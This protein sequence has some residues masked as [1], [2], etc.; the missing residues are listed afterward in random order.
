MLTGQPACGGSTEGRYSG[1]AVAQS[2]RIL[3]GCRVC[4]TNTHTHM[5][6]CTSTPPPPPRPHHH[7]RVAPAH[8]VQALKQRALQRQLLARLAED[9]GG[10]LLR[11]THHHDAP[12]CVAFAHSGGAW[13][14]C[15]EAS[16]APCAVQETAGTCTHAHTYACMHAQQHHQEKA[17]PSHTHTHTVRRTPG[18]A[19]WLPLP[20]ALPRR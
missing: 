8:H 11:V 6:D 1:S 14:G 17:A 9:G 3:R 19:G 18:A 16:W 20:P 12:V 2:Q 5:C 10:Q 4:S 15:V 7:G 13:R